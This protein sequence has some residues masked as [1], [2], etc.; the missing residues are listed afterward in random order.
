VTHLRLARCSSDETHLAAIFDAV[1]FPHLRALVLVECDSFVPDD[2]GVDVGVSLQRA[3]ARSALRE[4]SHPTL[5]SLR[6]DVHD[7]LDRARMAARTA[8]REAWVTKVVGASRAGADGSRVRFPRLRRVEVNGVTPHG[9]PSHDPFVP[10]RSA[11]PARQG[12]IATAFAWLCGRPE[13]VR[14]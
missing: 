3:F 13:T 2:V 8:A 10:P 5:R 1:R 6:V 11:E 14:L 12:R 9:W 4:V 7:D